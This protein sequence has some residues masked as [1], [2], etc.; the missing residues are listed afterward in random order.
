MPAERHIRRIVSAVVFVAQASETHLLFLRRRVDIQQLTVET[1]PTLA[2]IL[3]MATKYKIERPCTD[4]IAQIRAQWPATL[5]QHD[6]R[7][8]Q[9]R[10]L[11]PGEGEVHEDLVVH[12]ASVI[13]LLRECGYNEADILFPLFY[14]LSRTTWQFGGP[15]LGHHLVSLSAADIERFVVG[16]ERL[17]DRHATLVVTCPAFNMIPTNPPHFC[18]PPTQ[19]LWSSVVHTLLVRNGLIRAHEPLEEWRDMIAS[20]N[21]LYAQYGVCVHCHGAIV[22]KINAYRQ[23]LW[24]LL[25]AFFEL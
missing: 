14:A 10:A 6:A 20:I 4:I 7:Q 8:A 12:P 9:L 25:P 18:G 23:N 24:T 16:V 19:H 1:F 5:P 13:T 3:R 22:S 17:R 21:A 15:G 2:T 11:P